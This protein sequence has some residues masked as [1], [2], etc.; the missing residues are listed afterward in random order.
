MTTTPPTTIT[1]NKQQHEQFNNNNINT[2]NVNNPN[3]T[4]TTDNI[5][6]GTTITQMTSTIPTQQQQ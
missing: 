2:G 5:N 6:M 4:P 1:N 3:Q